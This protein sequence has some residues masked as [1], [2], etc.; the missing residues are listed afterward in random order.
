MKPPK[1]K[2]V[3][4]KLDSKTL[5]LM[6]DRVSYV[7]SPEHKDYPS[8]LTNAKNVHPRLDASICP[9]DINNKELVTGWLKEAIIKGAID[10]NFE[11]DFPRYVWYYDPDNRLAFAGRLTNRTIGQYKGYPINVSELPAGILKIWEN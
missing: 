6:A 9:K 1:M 3:S 8:K 11:N 10:T 2:H 4:P 5:E 7:G